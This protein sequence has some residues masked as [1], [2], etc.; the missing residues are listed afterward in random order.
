MSLKGIRKNRN[1]TQKELAQL[2]GVNFRT[3]QDYEQGHKKLSSASGEVLLRLSAALGC[4][5]DE[6]LFDNSQGAELL[7]SN[8]MDIIA[9]QK[10]QLYCEKYNTSGRWVCCNDKIS[11]LFYYDGEQYLVPFR[12]VFTEAMLPFLIEAA[13]FHMEMKIDDVLWQRSDYGSW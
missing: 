6:L 9:I 13:A 12:A 11:I 1:L 10:Q 2:S 5:T 4:T 3:L 8:K 7:P